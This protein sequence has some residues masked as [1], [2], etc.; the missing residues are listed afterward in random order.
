MDSR[1]GGG[2]GMSGIS[3]APF[4]AEAP[5]SARITTLDS[6]REHLQCCEDGDLQARRTG[7]RCEDRVTIA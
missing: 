1:D 5:S 3:M 4:K 6:L 7:I 2:R